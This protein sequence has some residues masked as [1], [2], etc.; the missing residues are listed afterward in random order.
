MHLKSSC[1]S[2]DDPFGSSSSFVESD[3]DLCESRQS[4][5]SLWFLSMEIRWCNLENNKSGNWLIDFFSFIQFDSR[6]YFKNAGTTYYFISGQVFRGPVQEKTCW[7]QDGYTARMD[8]QEGGRKQESRGLNGI[9][10]FHPYSRQNG[11]W[12]SSVSSPLSAPSDTRL[13]TPTAVPA[14]CYLP[15]G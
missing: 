1:V 11:L 10:L 5:R 3:V 2:S 7:C 13:S 12:L 8:I 15:K 9:L 14:C 6:W 4:A